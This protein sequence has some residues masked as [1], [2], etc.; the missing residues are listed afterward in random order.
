MIFKIKQSKV[1]LNRVLD[2][3]IDL[4]KPIKMVNHPR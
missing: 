4:I 1:D 3:K 2:L